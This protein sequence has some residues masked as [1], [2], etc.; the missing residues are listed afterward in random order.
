[1]PSWLILVLIGAVLI[2]CLGYVGWIASSLL[3]AALRR[4]E[5]H[6]LDAGVLERLAAP[7]TDTSR[8]SELTRLHDIVDARLRKLGAEHPH[9]EAA[10]TERCTY[11]QLSPRRPARDSA[12]IGFPR[13]P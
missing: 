9:Y 1:M 8:L 13:S 7:G 11:V 12:V 10:W 5:I 6:R 4:R 3:T 2:A